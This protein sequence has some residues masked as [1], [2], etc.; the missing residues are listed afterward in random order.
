[1]E[2]SSGLNAARLYPVNTPVLGMTLP[3]SGNG[4]QSS[5]VHHRDAVGEIGVQ[6]VRGSE[7]IVRK[8]GLP[9]GD[10]ADLPAFECA[11]GK[12]FGEMTAA[13]SDVRLVDEID[14]SALPGVEARVAFLTPQVERINREISVGDGGNQRVGRIIQSVSPGVG[15]LDLQAVVA[16]FRDLDLQTVVPGMSGGLVGEGVEERVVVHGVER[17]NARLGAKIQIGELQ[18]CRRHSQAEEVG[19]QVGLGRIAVN[20]AENSGGVVADV[21]RVNGETLRQRALH[22]DVPGGRPEAA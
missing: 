7:D 1:M 9:C 11:P 2:G 20:H 6:S 18:I 16:L 10:T 17:K 3:R 8:T 22:A 13:A 12:T 21:V 15:A 4:F 5:N 14:H 19:D